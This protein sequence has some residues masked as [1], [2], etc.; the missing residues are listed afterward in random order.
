[1]D[2]NA[3]YEYGQFFSSRRIC[4]VVMPEIRRSGLE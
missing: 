1:M 4:L 2:L 3:V